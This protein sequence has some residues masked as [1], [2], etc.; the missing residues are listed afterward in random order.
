MD[1]ASFLNAIIDDGI[2]DIRLNYQRPDQ[3][4]K[5]EGGIAGFSECRGLS[6]EDLLEAGNNVRRG[7]PM[8]TP[9]FN[10]AKE[11]DIEQMLEMAGLD[12][13]AQSTLYDGRTGE[14]FDRKVT[15]GY[16][17]MLKLHHLVDDKIHARSI[18]P[19]CALPPSGCWVTR[20][21]G[22]IDR[23]WILSSTRWCS[24]SM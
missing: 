11:A 1:R 14:P 5:K 17:Y 24:F 3:A 8:A 7:V 6:D 22:P 16:I 23:A 13:S 2:E 4:M 18:G 10:G 19:N 15:M 12:R 20:E 9:V 21:Y